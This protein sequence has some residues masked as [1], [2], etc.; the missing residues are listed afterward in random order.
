MH[1]Y[2]KLTIGLEA[3]ECCKMIYAYIKDFPDSEKFG[4]INQLQRAAVSIASNIAEGSS[5]T[6]QKDFIRFLEI[7]LGS[8]FEVETQI[9]IALKLNYLKEETGKYNS[10]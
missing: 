2:K 9:I 4:L 3:V 10:N 1:N 8:S 5:R 6:S 7:A